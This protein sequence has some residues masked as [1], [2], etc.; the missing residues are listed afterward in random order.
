MVASEVHPFAKTGGLA[1]VVGALPRAL[2]SG[3]PSLSPYRNFKC[4][5]GQW[6]FIAAANDRCGKNPRD[7]DRETHDQQTFSADQFRHYAP[8]G[9]R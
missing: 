3:H 4:R 2:G 8:L 9:V 1:D 5:D 6:I 7:G